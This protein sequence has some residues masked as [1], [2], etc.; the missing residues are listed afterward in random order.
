VYLISLGDYTK[1]K[2]NKTKQR[3]LRTPTAWEDSHAVKLKQQEHVHR[4][5][6]AKY[7]FYKQ[8]YFISS[9]AKASSMLS[10]WHIDLFSHFLAFYCG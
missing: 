8:L 6:K 10:S 2:Q 4:K 7:T 9:V 5:A 1:R 3:L